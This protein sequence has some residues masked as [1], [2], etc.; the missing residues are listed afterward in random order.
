MLLKHI[1]FVIAAC[2]L[3]VSSLTMATVSAD[4]APEK[5]R[6]CAACHGSAGISTKPHIPN[7]AGQKKD[8]LINEIKDYRKGDREDPLMSPIAKGLSDSDIEE[9]ATYFSNLD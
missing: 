7:L 9:L 6:I 2:S 4:N 5:S 3:M 8:Y 1:T